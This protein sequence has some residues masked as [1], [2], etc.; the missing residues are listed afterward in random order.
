[1]KFGMMKFD[2]ARSGVGGLMCLSG[3]LRRM[4]RQ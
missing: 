2:E 3:D 1:M 4:V